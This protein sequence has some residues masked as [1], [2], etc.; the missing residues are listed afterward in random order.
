MQGRNTNMRV[1]Y[2]LLTMGRISGKSGASSG[3]KEYNEQGP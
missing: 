1:S 2:L 3:R